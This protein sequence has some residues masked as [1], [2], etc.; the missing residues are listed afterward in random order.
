MR[1]AVLAILILLPATVSAE[2]TGKQCDGAT[3][4]ATGVVSGRFEII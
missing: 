1:F 4:S 2:I 3:A